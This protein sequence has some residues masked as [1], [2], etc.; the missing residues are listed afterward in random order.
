MDYENKEN[1]MKKYW[2]LLLLLLLLAL[3]IFL[4]FH[5]LCFNHQSQ[6]LLHVSSTQTGI[7]EE[8]RNKI[9]DNPIILSGHGEILVNSKYPYVVLENVQGNNVYLR[10]SVYYEDELLL[11]TD[12]ISPGMCEKF[13]IYKLF[14]PGSYTLDYYVSAYDM[15]SRTPYWSNV[16]IKQKIQIN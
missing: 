5:F 7:S 9:D 14:K 10:Y 16:N 12:L 1:K 8:D 2:L 6:E 3:I 11:T 4:I 15:N 13:D